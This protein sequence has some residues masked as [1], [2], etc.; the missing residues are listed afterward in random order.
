MKF[1][2]RDKW[3]NPANLEHPINSERKDL[4]HG[5]VDFTTDKILSTLNRVTSFR[6]MFVQEGNATMCAEE[7]CMYISLTKVIIVDNDYDISFFLK[8]EWCIYEF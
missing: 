7:T 2:R 4:K 5:T 1:L 8:T 6:Y 3:K